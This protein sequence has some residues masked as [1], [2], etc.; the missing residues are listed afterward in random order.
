[1]DPVTVIVSALALGAAAGFEESTTQAVK[2]AYAALKRLISDRY[3]QVDTAPVERLPAS[4][5]KRGSLAED[6]AEAG[7]DTDVEVLEAAR[8]LITTLKAH[9][10]TSGAALGIDLE[11]VEAAA[12]RIRTVESDGTGVRVRDGKFSGDID[13][14]GVRAGR[15]QPD[16]P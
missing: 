16:L 10:A 9:D 5:A 12:L 6:L 15:G 1:V 2:D 3:R 11:H 8:S 4:E 14:E 7:A 13:I